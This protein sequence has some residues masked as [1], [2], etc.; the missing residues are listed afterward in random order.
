[1]TSGGPNPLDV[2]N[3]LGAGATAD[4]YK[5]TLAPHEHP[6]DRAHRHRME[7]RYFA[8]GISLLVV[9]LAT[10]IA[11]VGWNADPDMRKAGAALLT[12]IVSGALGFVAGKGSR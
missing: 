9:I 11:M 4:A 2:V 5:V 8:A 10:A 1:M 7:S 12:A 3:V 6:D